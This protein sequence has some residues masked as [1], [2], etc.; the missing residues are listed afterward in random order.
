[1]PSALPQ[2]ALHPVL[3]TL[4]EQLLK[5]RLALLK[6]SGASSSVNYTL[7]PVP[8]HAPLLV[9]HSSGP[10][11]IAT[12]N[13]TRPPFRCLFYLLLLLEGNNIIALTIAFYFL[14]LAQFHYPGGG[15]CY[16]SPLTYRRPSA[17]ASTTHL[18]TTN[19]CHR[20]LDVS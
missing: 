4:L 7:V 14:F 9:P 12:L 17:R 6:P 2:T 3:S 18:A 16:S 19:S 15:I 20:P 10:R 13:F 5:T 11:F 8:R 1:M